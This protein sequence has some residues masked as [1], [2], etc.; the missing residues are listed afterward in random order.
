[1]LVAGDVPAWEHE[2]AYLSAAGAE[3]EAIAPP[4]PICYRFQTMLATLAGIDAALTTWD[5][6][7]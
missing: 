7:D 4:T 2:F 6:C 5:N 3:T 1:M